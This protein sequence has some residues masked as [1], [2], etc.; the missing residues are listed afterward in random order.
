MKIT[1]EADFTPLMLAEAFCDMNDEDQAQF[2]IEVTAIMGRWGDRMPG[3]VRS[4]ARTDVPVSPGGGWWAVE[5]AVGRVA[6]GIPGR[7]DRLRMLGNA[8]VPQCAEVI[9]RVIKATCNAPC[10]RGGSGE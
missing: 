1:V 7:L 3:D 9:G 4:S 8:V 10:A 5:P 6:D 2:F